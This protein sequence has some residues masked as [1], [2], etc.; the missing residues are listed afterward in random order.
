MLSHYLFEVCSF[1][2]LFIRD[3]RICQARAPKIRDPTWPQNGG[4]LLCPMSSS[5][6]GSAP[7]A[8]S[9]GAPGA[10]PAPPRGAG[11]GSPGSWLVRLPVFLRWTPRRCSP[12]GPGGGGPAVLAP[13]VEPVM[14]GNPPGQQAT[15]P[16]KPRLSPRKNTFPENRGRQNLCLTENCLSHA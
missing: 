9:P 10:P 15:P 3:I 13:R 5:P 6:A 11:S 1:V 12:C 4:P 14:V 8:G 16:K 7:L 2:Y